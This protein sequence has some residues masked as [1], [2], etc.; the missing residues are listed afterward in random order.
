MFLQIF[1]QDESWVNENL[2]PDRGWHIP[3]HEVVGMS[4]SNVHRDPWL[5][6]VG[7]R[8]KEEL[9]GKNQKFNIDRIGLKVKGQGH[10]TF[11]R[12]R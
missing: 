5:R 12:E 1:Y 11:L 6:G 10:I 3:R 7:Y 2:G 9:I 4:Q 8:F